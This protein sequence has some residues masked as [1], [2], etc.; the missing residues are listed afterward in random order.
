MNYLLY[1]LRVEQVAPSL[2][3]LKKPSVTNNQ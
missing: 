2:N 3:L 1:V